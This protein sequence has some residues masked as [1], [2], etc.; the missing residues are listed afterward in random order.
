M[1]QDQ[2]VV[3]LILLVFGGLNTIRPE[4]LM[5][6][7][8]WFQKTVMDAKYEPSSR[9]YKIIRFFGVVLVILGLTVLT[10]YWL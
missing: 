7:Q 1:E 5:R 6:F 10:G 9:T 4:I 8:I 3:G 2:L